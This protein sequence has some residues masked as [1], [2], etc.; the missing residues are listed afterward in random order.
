MKKQNG[1]SL[2]LFFVFMLP[3]TSVGILLMADYAKYTADTKLTQ[4][5]LDDALSIGVKMLPYKDEAEKAIRVYVSNLDAEHFG[6]NGENL[7]LTIDGDKIEGFISSS[8]RLYFSEILSLLSGNAERAQA[9]TITAVSKA[10][11]TPLDTFLLVDMG[12]EKLSP[13]D[14]RNLWG[15]NNLWAAGYFFEAMRPFLN[16]G[17][18]E[19]PR[20]STQNCF[21]PFLSQYKKSVIS[22]YNY[23]S[24]HQRDQIGVGV[25][26]GAQ[27]D[28]S[29][30]RKVKNRESQDASLDG[31][32]SEGF[33]QDYAEANRADRFCAATA[34]Q[35]NVLS[36]YK[37]PQESDSLSTWTPPAPISIPFILP[38]SWEFNSL[39]YDSTPISK[40]L[41]SLVTRTSNNKSFTQALL[42]SMLETLTAPRELERD[43]IKSKEKIVIVISPRV[44]NVEP[45]E[46]LNAQNIVEEVSTMLNSSDEN[47]TILYF[48]IRNP[49]LNP[50]EELSPQMQKQVTNLSLNSIIGDRENIKSKTFIAVDYDQLKNE[51]LPKILTSLRTGVLSS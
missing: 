2:M 17:V 34:E 28:L 39:N 6:D 13:L 18:E 14:D 22:L 44:F 4:T 20:Y 30:I 31:S 50:G 40:T 36:H 45:S 29:I 35:E 43:N 11:Q 19:N 27:S 5:V 46:L 1:S 9:V 25:F 49:Y 23:L 21:N 15:D 48:I 10:R 26:P 24:N 33:F 51:L 41:W 3:L 32:K 8:T 7:E 47:L 12:K 42:E 37:F 16:N 38:G